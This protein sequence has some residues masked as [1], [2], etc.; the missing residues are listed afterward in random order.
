MISSRWWIYLLVIPMISWM[1][2][3]DIASGDDEIPSASDVHL[4]PLDPMAGEEFDIFV[5]ISDTNLSREYEIF[6]NIESISFKLERYNTSDI[7]QKY[8]H[9]YH[10]TI[11]LDR[12]GALSFNVTTKI[13]SNTTVLLSGEL[14]ITE[15]PSDEDD[16]ILGLPRWWCGISVIIGTLFIIFLTWAYFKGRSLR[17]NGMN[18]IKKKATCS[19]CGSYINDGDNICGKCGSDLD[20]VEYICGKCG[21][22]ITQGSRSCPHC[23]SRLKKGIGEKE[24]TIDQDLGKLYRDTDMKGKVSCPNCDG[25]ISITDR[26]CPACN[27]KLS[28]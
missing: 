8:H 13:E 19:S 10:S 6:L 11:E 28:I 23:G 5:Y 20:E 12:A 22:Q 15:R 16:T 26:T 27:K 3:L 7:G 1:I 4:V 2:S 14:R 24:Q 25:I 21:K 17:K 18:D 9:L